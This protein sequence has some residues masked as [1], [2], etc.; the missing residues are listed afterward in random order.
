MNNNSERIRETINN[1]RDETAV[2]EVKDLFNVTMRG[3]YDVLKD[4]LCIESAVTGMC[5]EIVDAPGIDEATKLRAVEVGIKVKRLSLQIGERLGS[6]TE[7]IPVEFPPR[8][9]D[10]DCFQEVEV[11]A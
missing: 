4:L 5:D 2:K 6:I 7:N 9:D 8:I 11:D 3:V 1:L 10:P